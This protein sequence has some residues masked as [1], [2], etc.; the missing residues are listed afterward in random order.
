ML[1]Q[2][3]VAQGNALFFV[4]FTTSNHCFDLA[5]ASEEQVKIMQLGYYSRHGLHKQLNT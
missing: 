2:T 3:R 1:Q 5:W 4:H